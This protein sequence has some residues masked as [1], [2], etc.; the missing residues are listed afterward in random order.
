MMEAKRKYLLKAH[1]FYSDR[2]EVLK[3]EIKKLKLS[4]NTEAF[5]QHPDVKFAVRLRNATMQTI[6]DDPDK[7][8]INCAGP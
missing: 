3:A 1:K 8:N 6:P 4:L 7:K 2:I 5:E